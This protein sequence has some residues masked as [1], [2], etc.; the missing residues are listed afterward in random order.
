MALQIRYGTDTEFESGKSNIL[1]GEMGITTDT[2]RSVVGVDDGEY[3]ELLNI[4]SLAPAYDS[5]ETYTTGDVCSYGGKLYVLMGGSATGA[6]DSSLWEETTL[7]EVMEKLKLGKNTT[8]ESGDIVS[9]TNP[10]NRALPFVSVKADITAQQDLHGQANPYPAGGG[11]NLLNNTA[12]TTT[13]SQVTFTVNA[14]GTVSTSG[15][16]NGTA[17]L[18][19]WQTFSQNADLIINGCP[20]GGSY[21][22]T[23]CIVPCTDNGSV[24]NGAIDT[25]EGVTIPA[26][27][28]SQIKQIQIIVRNGT[29]VSGKVFKPMV[30]LASITDDTFAPY[31]NICPITGFT[32]ANVY[33]RGV[34]QWDEEWELG[35]YNASNGQTWDVTNRIRSKSTNYIPIL[36]N[37]E[38][39]VNSPKSI[40]CYFYDVNK[41]YISYFGVTHGTTFTTPQNARYFRFFVDTDYGTTYNNDISINYPSTDHD[42]H[43]YNGEDYATSFGSTVYGGTLNVTTGVLTVTHA[44]VDLGS[45]SWGMSPTSTFYTNPGLS[46]IKTGVPNDKALDYIICSHYK[47]APKPGAAQVGDKMI[48]TGS[49]NSKSSNVIIIRD[50]SYTDSTTFKTAMDGVQLVYELATPTEVQLT[51]IEMK[52]LLGQ[53]NIW[54]DTGEVEV[55]YYTRG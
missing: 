25:G 55:T 43:A 37:T 20:S 23:Y 3:M 45:L 18:K 9:F 5:S 24:V 11:K 30:R 12:T 31:S 4:E 49:S 6:W 7:G 28:V 10:Y 14:D 16:A 48:G 19:I 42:Y 50:T 47:T 32:G 39:Y 54:A 13:S 44:E 34:N 51:P 8:T 17:V 33:V 41:N 27:Y 35:A 21:Y 29:N 26:E 38:Y 53:N 46:E 15:T 2:E 1:S 40:F 52:T 22:N 36:P